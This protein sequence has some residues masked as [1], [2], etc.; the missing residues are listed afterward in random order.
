MKANCNRYNK[1]NKERGRTRKRWRN[2]FEEDFKILGIKNRQAIVSDRQEWRKPRSTTDCS[3]WKGKEK[4][5]EGK[6]EKEEELS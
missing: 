6:G 3:A 1:R 2:G 5:K 4:G